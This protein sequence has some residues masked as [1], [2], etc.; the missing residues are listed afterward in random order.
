MSFPSIC[1]VDECWPWHMPQEERKLFVRNFKNTNQVIGVR[2][3]IS[4]DILHVV[5]RNLIFFVKLS[6]KIQI[7]KSQVVC[8]TE[9]CYR[10]AHQIIVCAINVA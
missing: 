1:R 7:W 10:C 4:V 9:L 8:D 5:T 2:P 6:R 3:G